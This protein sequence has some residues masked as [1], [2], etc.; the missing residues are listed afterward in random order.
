[1]VR[2]ADGAAVACLGD[3]VT[4]ASVVVA[5]VVVVVEPT[6]V[7]AVAVAQRQSADYYV[8]LPEPSV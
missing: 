2:D 3:E 5:T 4:Y 6:A 7:A 8:E 1:M